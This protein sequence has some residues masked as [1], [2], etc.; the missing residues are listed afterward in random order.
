MEWFK[1]NVF[2]KPNLPLINDSL[3]ACNF[4]H[5]WPGHGIA[6]SCWLQTDTSMIIESSRPPTA[7]FERSGEVQ[8]VGVTV[9]LAT[10]MI[11]YDIYHNRIANTYCVFIMRDPT[12]HN[13]S[14]KTLRNLSFLN[15]CNLTVIICHE[16]LILM[17]THCFYVW[18]CVILFSSFDDYFLS[19]ALEAFTFTFTPFNG[20]P[21]HTPVGPFYT[22]PSRTPVGPFYT[23]SSNTPVGPHSTHTPNPPL[24]QGVSGRWSSS[25]GSDLSTGRSLAT[26]PSSSS[27]S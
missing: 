23:R 3:G 26:S 24:L 18:T 16:L 11:W 1:D 7:T 6:K 12:A 13:L 5:N 25:S 17:P 19:E 20:G 2:W 22:C 9:A 21:S 8:G 14:H 27:T 15:V 10:A 4:Q